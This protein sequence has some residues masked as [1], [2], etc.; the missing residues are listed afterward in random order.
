MGRSLKLPYLAGIC[1]IGLSACGDPLARVDKLS[2]VPLGDV[3]PVRGA[4]A[5]PEELAREGGLFGG[6]FQRATPEQD[7]VTVATAEAETSLDQ[8]APDAPE[9]TETAA[10]EGSEP[11]VETQDA[12]R[13]GGLLGLFRRSASEPTPEPALEAAAASEPE[14]QSGDASVAE[15][16]AAAQSERRGLFGAFR[17]D[18]SG[19]VTQDAPA[20]DVQTASLAPVNEGRGARASGGGLFGRSAAAPR[21]GPDAADVAFG[22]VLPFGQVARVCE[23]KGRQ[24]GKMIEKAGRGRGYQIHD[25]APGSTGP[26]TFYVTGFSDGCPRQFTAALALFGAPSMH[27]QLRYGRPSDQYPYSA[28]DKAYE[29]VKSSVCKVSRRKPCGARIGVLERD[30]VFISTYERFTNNGRWADILIHDGAVLAAS[31]KDL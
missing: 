7:P 18:Q 20:E 11:R 27:E 1:L 16:T 14:V 30:T 15:Q 19:E 22:T 3:D 6:L 5:S 21:K 9:S 4:L 17:R 13:S 25:S 31:L 8:A 26:R 23:A 24:M 2:D 29:K 10:A 12:P 28:T